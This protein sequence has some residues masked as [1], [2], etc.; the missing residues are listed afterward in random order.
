MTDKESIQKALEAVQKSTNDV[1]TGNA[2]IDTKQLTYL[3][4]NEICKTLKL[5]SQ[6]IDELQEPKAD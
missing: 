3:A 1:L 6:Q 4:L 2:G 5:I